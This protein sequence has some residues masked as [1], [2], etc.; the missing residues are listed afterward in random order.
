MVSKAQAEGRKKNA[1]EIYMGYQRK[2]EQLARHALRFDEGEDN[3]DEMAIILRVLTIDKPSTQSRS[4]LS[5]LGIAIKIRV[6]STCAP[7]NPNNL[8]P[9][10]GLVIQRI[11]SEGA[12]YVAP[13]GDSVHGGHL[14]NVDDWLNEIVIKAREFVF[15]RAE[16]IKTIANGEGGAHF[17]REYNEGHYQLAYANAFGWSIL[18]PDGTIE[19]F[20]DPFPAAIRQITYEVLK[21]DALIKAEGWLH[22]FGQ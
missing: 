1:R 12:S 13:L 14:L 3:F 20:G 11:N 21:M 17:D 19:N 16:I 4:I 18:F 7:F 5:T 8:L 9:T 22:E 15:S 10:N 2:I 6:L